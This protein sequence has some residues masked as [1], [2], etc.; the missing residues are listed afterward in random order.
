MAVSVFTEAELEYLRGGRQL[1]LMPGPTT[2]DAATCRRS[3][4]RIARCPCWAAVPPGLRRLT[5][6]PA[7]RPPPPARRASAERRM[8]LGARTSGGYPGAGRFGLRAATT[9]TCGGWITAGAWCCP[10]LC[11]IHLCR[12]TLG[13]GSRTREG[14][15]T[16]GESSATP[17]WRRAVASKGD[18]AG[19][20]PDVRQ[21]AGHV[22][23]RTPAQATAGSVDK[24][25]GY[26]TA[27]DVRVPGPCPVPTDGG[28]PWARRGV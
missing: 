3:R 27:R 20:D 24:G 2:A 13:S 19:V 4:S 12:G 25:R 5:A 17:R 15:R 18:N 16:R 22:R 10:N 28:R 14:S 7:S 26:H 8:T 11:A 6:T 9:S 1:S 21:R 23:A